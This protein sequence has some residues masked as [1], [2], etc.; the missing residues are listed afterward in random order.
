MQRQ[1]VGLY[2]VICTLLTRHQK[3]LW[4][5]NY[6][7]AQQP[8]QTSLLLYI[9]CKTGMFVLKTH[10]FL[11]ANLSLNLYVLSS[12]QRNFI[13]YWKFVGLTT[14]LPVVAQQGAWPT[15]NSRV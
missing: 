12:M 1:C 15:R 5:S 14:L 3:H 4:M 8:S 9:L 11:S 13:N 6:V 7:G 10:Q 2:T